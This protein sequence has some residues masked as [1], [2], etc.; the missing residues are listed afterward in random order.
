M[1]FMGLFFYVELWLL[2]RKTYKQLLHS[3]K[4]VSAKVTSSR[5]VLSTPS[6]A[7]L[8]NILELEVEGEDSKKLHFIDYTW[9]QTYGP[10]LKYHNILPKVGDKVIILFDP[11]NTELVAFKRPLKAS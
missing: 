3:G 8:P 9:K 1:T 5:I 7:R 10:L 4:E 6:R 11:N 2:C